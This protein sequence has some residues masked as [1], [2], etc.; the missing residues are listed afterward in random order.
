MHDP[1]L[2]I[3]T[4]HPEDRERVLAEVAR[5]DETGEPFRIECR[6]ITRD[7]RVIWVRDETVLVKT[8]EGKPLYWQGVIL[9]VTERKA[10]EEQLEYQAFHDPLTGLPNR[11]LFTDLLRQA[12]A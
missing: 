12:L 11:T 4:T 3:K 10:L 9:D 6:K 7:G 8:P 2:W 1:D 5:T